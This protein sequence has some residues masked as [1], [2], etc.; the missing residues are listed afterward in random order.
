MKGGVG[1]SALLSGTLLLTGV[2][3]F[4]QIV[5]FFY[6][7]ALSRLVG[8]ETMGLYQLLMPAYSL[9]MSLTASG[10]TVAVS[11]LTAQH[12]ALGRPWAIRQTRNRALALFF[13]L[14]LPLGI[15]VVLLSDPI[16]VH[17]LGDARTRL[18]LMLLVPCIWLTGVENLHK[19]CFYGM[20]NPRPP[21]ASET[22][23]QLVRA[24]AVLALLLLFLPQNRERT[25]G[26]IVVGMIVCELFSS[27][28]LLTLFRSLPHPPPHSPSSVSSIHM[29][30]I[31]IPVSLTSLLG[32][33]LS[34]ANSVLIPARLV[35]GG[36]EP[37]QAISAFGIL[38]GMTM[39]LLALPTGFIG[40]LCL[41]LVPHLAR[42]T[43]LGDRQAVAAFLDRVLSATSLL[44]APAMAL[45]A[46][47]GPQLAAAVY[48]Q[49]AAGAHMTPL[50]L[51]TLLCCYQSVL[52]GALNGI[53]RQRD[54]ALS[55]LLSDLLQL[56]FTVLAVPRWGLS[57]FVAGFVLSAGAGTALNLCALCRSGGLRLQLL[58]WFVSP[59][60][61]ALLMGLC[62]RLCFL[63]A[64]DSGCPLPIAGGIACTLGLAVYLAALQ[65]QGLLL[66]PRHL[67]SVR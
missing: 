57:A 46:V 43:A 45:L 40:A 35:A 1:M 41:V 36:M 42:Q 2:G 8:A 14:A 11:S 33:L 39:P 22:V 31:A 23:E 32:T 44:M 65:A 16:S 52:S 12:Q 25:L 20:G 3:L 26:L 38:C 56:A 67:H 30:S 5:G 62:A 13:L 60:L 29:L 63:V 47:V 6:R 48:R 53:E 15:L 21:A 4:T 66:R 9:L 61:S 37:T 28:T 51:G 64:C 55:A 49:P 18:G 34:S 17:L 19:H 50:A 58:R 24:G 7:I 59:L 54:A 10:L 27:L